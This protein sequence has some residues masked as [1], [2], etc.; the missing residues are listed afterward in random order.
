MENIVYSDSRLKKRFLVFWPFCARSASKF[1]K[2]ANITTKKYFQLILIWVLKNA[3]FDA[4][5]E[6]V[7]K[8]VQKFLRNKLLA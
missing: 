2:S 1:A 4:D 7:E 6:S 8:V 3:E 5:F